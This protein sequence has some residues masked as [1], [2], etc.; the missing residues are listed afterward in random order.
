M[1]KSISLENFQSWKKGQFDFHPGVNIIIGTSCHGKSSVIRALNY[2]R[3]NRPL[4]DDFISHWG[5]NTIIGV[6][7]D[8]GQV[9]RVKGEH[10]N[11]YCTNYN[12]EY[13]AFN[14]GVPE[15]VTHLLNMG[16]INFQNQHDPP[17]LLS[18]SPPDTAKYLNKIVNLEKIDT[19]TAHANKRIRDIESDISHTV[20]EIAKEK[21]SLE[22]YSWLK[23]AET[24]IAHLESV[25]KRIEGLFAYISGI[26]SLQ[27]DIEHENKGIASFNE[28]IEVE[29]D[30]DQL[31]QL[32]A[33]I[34]IE[35]NQLTELTELTGRIKK[36][37]LYVQG[38]NTIINFN[39]PVD[40]ILQTADTIT[41][42]QREIDELIQLINTIKKEGQKAIDLSSVLEKA[43]IEFHT[44]MPEECP[45]CGNPTGGQ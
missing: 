10:C 30:V 31:L 28:E 6:G 29:H 12:N 11:L 14:K 45:L 5:G 18:M 1:I 21:L 40:S 3:F 44:L 41:A 8:R 22:E 37:E 35:A 20:G 7:S 17:F 27:H 2:V 19:S 38:I 9:Q 4:G 32:I 15:E 34:E 33:S 23:Q 24:D 42:E 25:Q 43:E 36:G 13:K 26:A 16:P 39:S